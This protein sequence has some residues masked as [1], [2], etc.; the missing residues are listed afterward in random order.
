[1]KP[2]RCTCG[3]SAISYPGGTVRCGGQPLIAA[4]GRVEPS[5]VAWNHDLDERMAI[6]EHDG[7]L[8]RE[9]AER[10]VLG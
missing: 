2:H 1:M 8:S 10:R 9:E 3:G 5:V 7:G 4:C 6:M